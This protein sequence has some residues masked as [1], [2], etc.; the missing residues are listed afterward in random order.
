MPRGFKF[1][2]ATLLR[3]REMARDERRS[4]LAEAYRAD[5]LVQQR[6]AQ[7]RRQLDLAA[8]ECR[9]AVG[10]GEVNLDRIVEAQ[11]FEVTMRAQQRQL[12]QQHEAIGREIERRR[13][14][15]LEANRQVR[16]LE[17]LRDHQE[18]R[19]REQQARREIKQLDEVA[20]TRAGRRGEDE[21]WDA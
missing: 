15:L 4:H 1:R 14:N 18:R 6:I 19:H 2:L 12:Q 11:R 8:R 13:E 21:P 10:P 17:Q 7:V 16:I 9:A 3:L 5:E 20:A